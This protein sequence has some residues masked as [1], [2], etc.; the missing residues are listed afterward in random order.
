MAYGRNAKFEEIREVAFGAIGATYGAIGALTTDYTRLFT[1]TNETNLPVYISLDG[2]T[3]HLRIASGVTRMFNLTANKARDDGLFLPKGTV[4][5]ARD[6]GVPPGSGL[7][8]IEV[9]YA[10]GGV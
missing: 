9:M 3:D 6:S 4:F 2:V 7:V 5:Y 1:I 10:S 8:A